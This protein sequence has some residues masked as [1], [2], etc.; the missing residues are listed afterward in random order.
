[1]PLIDRRAALAAAAGAA[2]YPVFAAA[3]IASLEIFTV[4]E[5]GDGDDQLARAIAEGLNTTRLLPNSGAVGVPGDGGEKG[6]AQFVSGARPR[7]GL[8][9]LGLGSLGPLV[10]RKADSGL[11]GCR[12]LA[13]LIGEAQPIVVLDKSPIRTFEDLVRTMREDPGKLRWAG[14]TAG[15]ADHQLVLQTAAAMGADPARINYIAGDERTEVSIKLMRGEADVGTADLGDLSAQ[16]RGGVLRPLA[17]SSAQRAP[18]FDIPTFHEQ[19]V[20]LTFV[21]WRGVFARRRIEQAFFQRFEDAMQTLS[22]LTGWRQL[23]AARN[24]LDIYAPE[25]DFARL[26]TDE[27]ARLKALFETAQIGG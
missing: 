19:G 11:E 21:N 9:V 20:P 18:G 25:A 24:W 10:L 16:I 14:R 17:I 1:L 23:S 15:G 4:T 3:Q 7:P 13:L 5:A 8:L 2:L 22:Q 26:V 6:L 27:R 12:P